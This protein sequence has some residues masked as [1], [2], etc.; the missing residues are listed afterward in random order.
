M[1]LT[2][3]LLKTGCY[4]AII[5]ASLAVSA[6]VSTPTLVPKKSFCAYQ[7]A[8]EKILITGYFDPLEQL[9]EFKGRREARG[10][11]E[12][13]FSS[14]IC[15]SSFTDSGNQFYMGEGC[16]QSSRNS[17]LQGNLSCEQTKN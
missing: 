11:S 14:F 8:V 15:S 16:F 5:G 1:R 3:I 6:F 12:F 9:F 10:V 17:R 7:V 2:H 13:S 4:I